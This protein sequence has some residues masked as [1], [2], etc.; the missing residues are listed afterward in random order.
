MVKTMTYKALITGL[1]CAANLF[2]FAATI[3][4]PDDYPTI[5]EAIDAS[6]A[7][8]TIVVADGFVADDSSQNSTLLDN[9]SKARLVITKGITLRSVSGT[10]D[11]PVYIC[12]RKHSTA[13]DTVVTNHGPNSV[14]ALYLKTPADEKAHF[15]GIAFIN[16]CT[17]SGSSTGDTTG[18]GVWCDGCA[19]SP[20]FEDCVVSNNV[21]YTGGG[22]YA[23]IVGGGLAYLTNCLI[24]ANAVTNSVGG[25]Y[26][27]SCYRT[28]ISYNTAANTPAAAKYG[29]FIECQIIGN[30]RSRNTTGKYNNQI[31][32]EGGVLKK[33]LFKDNRGYGSQSSGLLYV[34]GEIRDCDFSNNLSPQ[35]LIYQGTKEFYNCR[36]YGTTPSKFGD[37]YT[38]YNCIVT[39]CVYAMDQTMPPLFSN[40]KFYNCILSNNRV[41][42]PQ[43]KLQY[44]NHLNGCTLYNCTFVLTS[45]SRPDPN[46]TVQSNEIKNCVLINTVFEA[47]D[48]YGIN[49]KK[50]GLG[51]CG[52]LYATNS[53]LPEVF[54][55]SNALKG[56]SNN[57]YYGAESECKKTGLI[58]EGDKQHQLNKG[59]VCIDSG[60]D[61]KSEDNPAGFAYL[62]SSDANE[63]YGIDYFGSKRISGKAVDIGAS[64]R[65]IPGFTIR[66]R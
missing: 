62:K 48:G 56:A 51:D 41:G 7:G 55:L 50:S 66:V 5:Q 38:L 8:D 3:N 40:S 32:M 49:A 4:V 30:A 35:T 9:G 54:V 37:G 23:D 34:T 33:C 16:G 19:E 14:R 52:N 36:F 18:A 21:A 64:E 31:I 26:K 45:F 11:N 20:V 1:I 57:I 43:Y 60:W 42:K 63:F 2:A 6:S 27:C 22:I 61:G 47:I 46:K 15:K 53:C 28:T 17:G 65:A 58:T 39:N 29:D 24:T 12:G 59:S 25:T 10:L 44:A 13:E